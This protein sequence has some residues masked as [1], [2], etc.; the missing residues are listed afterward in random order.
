[1][2]THAVF[3]KVPAL[4]LNWNVV[5][6]QILEPLLIDMGTRETVPS[7][8]SDLPYVMERDDAVPGPSQDMSHSTQDPTSRSSGRQSFCHDFKIGNIPSRLRCVF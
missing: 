5:L 2:C 1:M 7:Q 3:Y 4:L 6:I 8:P